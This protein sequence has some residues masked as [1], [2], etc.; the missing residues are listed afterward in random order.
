MCILASLRQLTYELFGEAYLNN[1]HGC[2]IRRGQLVSHKALLPHYI[3]GR[4]NC[5][6]SSTIAFEKP[7]EEFQS[8]LDSY[9]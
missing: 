5:S 4:T 8:N 6:T 9:L 2:S 1:A 3:G 7:L